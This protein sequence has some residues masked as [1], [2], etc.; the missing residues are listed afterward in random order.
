MAS[1]VVRSYKAFHLIAPLAVKFFFF[2]KRL[3]KM[4]AG[5]ATKLRLEYYERMFN[6]LKGKSSA[7]VEKAT[8][9]TPML[10]RFGVT[11]DEVDSDDVLFE[12]RAIIYILYGNLLERLKT[13]TLL[14]H[15]LEM[16]LDKMAEMIEAIFDWQ[17]PRRQDGQTR[18][19]GNANETTWKRKRDDME[20]QAD[21]F[22]SPQQTVT[23]NDK[24]EKAE[25]RGPKRKFASMNGE[26]WSG[27]KMKSGMA[28]NC[29][30]TIGTQISAWP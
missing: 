3:M 15:H 11:R 26:G 29:I 25:Q 2:S 14:A 7:K 16:D 12:G 28:K 1:R 18:R 4:L 5:D 9:K 6:A 22:A 21:T 24:Y 8:P 27:V 30:A 17:Q 19:H 10:S 23:V 20:T 13:L